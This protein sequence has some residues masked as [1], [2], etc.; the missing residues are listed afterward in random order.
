MG[1]DSEDLFVRA[2]QAPLD[3]GLKYRLQTATQVR[4]AVLNLRW[5][6]VVLFAMDESSELQLLELATQDPRVT[7]LPSVPLSNDVRIS[8]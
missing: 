1:I 7:G 5:N 2:A 6:N 4:E 8:P 3:Y